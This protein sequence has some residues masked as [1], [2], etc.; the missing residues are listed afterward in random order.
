MLQKLISGNY[1]LTVFT[2]FLSSGLNHYF[3]I[4]KATLTAIFLSFGMFYVYNF[5]QKEL[6][7]L[8]SI[9]GVVV[10]VF[11]GISIYFIEINLISS[12]V[13]F[14]NVLISF[15]YI[16]PSKIALRKFPFLKNFLIAACWTSTFVV[17]PQVLCAN[18]IDWS[19][20]FMMYLFFMLLALPFDISHLE[21]DQGK[22]QTISTKF[23]I[24][25]T[26]F[27]LYTLLVCFVSW[28]IFFSVLSQKNPFYW[29]L[30]LQLIIS[31]SII[32]N[33]KS[34][35]LFFF[36]FDSLLIIIGLAFYFSK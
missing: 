2:F 20:I 8:T 9:I 6:K 33:I 17:F 31:I 34:P 10:L 32:S 24:R 4:R 16:Y 35:L 11:I 14:L 13:L 21:Q 28:N 26:Q 29:F 18:K 25:S 30:I 19:V 7:F 27:I 3:G 23:G 5:Q 22:I 36:S 15:F 1:F 12:I